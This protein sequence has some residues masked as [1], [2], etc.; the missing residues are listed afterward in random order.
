MEKYNIKVRIVYNGKY[1][2]INGDK[3]GENISDKK[4]KQ[5]IR[6][7]VKTNIIMN[8]FV[9]KKFGM[10]SEFNNNLC[11]SCQKMTMCPKVR[12][13]EKRDLKCYPYIRSGIEVVLINSEKKEKYEEALK[14]Y[15]D[16]NEKID[17]DIE[18][19]PELK[20]SFERQCTDDFKREVER[21]GVYFILNKVSHKMYT[22]FKP[23]LTLGTCCREKLPTI[24]IDY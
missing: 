12:D 23:A 4:I 5:H 13:I 2:L 17:F 10:N 20:E 7:K 6:D 1:Y 24:S 8:K 15:N 22:N 9:L 16:L 21:K 3:I 18:D 19:Y 14:T 11:G